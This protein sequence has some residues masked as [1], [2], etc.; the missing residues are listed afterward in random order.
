MEQGLWQ[1][2]FATGLPQAYLAIQ[3]REQERDREGAEAVTAFRPR[4]SGAEKV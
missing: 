4:Q 3:G 1:L 2:F